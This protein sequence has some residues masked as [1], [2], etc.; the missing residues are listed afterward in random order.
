MSHMKRIVSTIVV[1]LVILALL[2]SIGCDAVAQ[3]VVRSNVA[4]PSSEAPVALER[5]SDL[6][7]PLAAPRVAAE[8]S[9]TSI[10]LVCNFQAE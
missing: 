3:D 8:E 7:P 5:I 1:A 9:S 4:Y 6:R 2:V 10:T